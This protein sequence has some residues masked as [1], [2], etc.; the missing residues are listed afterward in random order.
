MCLKIYE[1]FIKLRIAKMDNLCDNQEKRE[2]VI[3]TGK[4]EEMEE[5]MAF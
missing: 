1:G 5:E 4:G 3:M 2:G